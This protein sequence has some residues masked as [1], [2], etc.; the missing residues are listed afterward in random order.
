MSDDD[1]FRLIYS[2]AAMNEPAELDAICDRANDVIYVSPSGQC[3]FTGTSQ[4]K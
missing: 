4:L 2:W 3:C 1:R